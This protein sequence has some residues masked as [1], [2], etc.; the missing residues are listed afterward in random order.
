MHFT[1]AVCEPLNGT[2]WFQVFLSKIL[3]NLRPFSSSNGLI[4]AQTYRFVKLSQIS[5]YNTLSK[6]GRNI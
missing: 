3:D 2:K 5:S 1:G 4:V 6:Q